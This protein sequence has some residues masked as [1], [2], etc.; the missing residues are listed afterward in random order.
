MF[1]NLNTTLATT[2]SSNSFFRI[3]EVLAAL[4]VT[5]ALISGKPPSPSTTIVLILLAYVRFTWRLRDLAWLK[6]MSIR[7]RQILWLLPVLML[8]AAHQGALNAREDLEPRL[9]IPIVLKDDSGSSPQMV[10]A[11]RRFTN[12]AILVFSDTKVLVVPNERIVSLGNSSP[13]P[14]YKVEVRDPLVEFA[15]SFWE[16]IKECYRK[17]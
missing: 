4:L 8:F 5:A 16:Q 2:I 14:A 10:R 13:N 3:V 9:Q 15:S 11:V 6:P 12:S 17:W 7:D 1:L